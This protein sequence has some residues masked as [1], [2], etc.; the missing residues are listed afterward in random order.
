MN[1]EF[2]A[3]QALHAVQVTTKLWRNRCFLPKGVGFGNTLPYLPEDVFGPL[4]RL[5]DQLVTY[6]AN[7]AKNMRAN[8][9]EEERRLRISPPHLNGS[10]QI[11]DCNLYSSGLDILAVVPVSTLLFQLGTPDDRFAEKLLDEHY[12]NS[13]RGDMT[14]NSLKELK[15]DY[16]SYGNDLTKDL[17]R[18]SQDT[19]ARTKALVVLSTR[20]EPSSASDDFMQGKLDG[21]ITYPHLASWILYKNSQR[22]IRLSSTGFTIFNSS[23]SGHVELDLNSPVPRLVPNKKHGYECKIAFAT[24][25]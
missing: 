22:D 25:L 19:Y 6:Y 15:S 24:I 18:F 2:T 20:F 3:D 13:V 7:S 16:T 21:L 9:L 12:P 8:L 17:W 4:Y 23:R 10:Q 11:A 14:P 5:N 1:I